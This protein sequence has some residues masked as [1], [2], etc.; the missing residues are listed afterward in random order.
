MLTWLCSCEATAGEVSLDTSGG[1][2]EGETPLPIPNRAVKPLSADGTWPL[3]PGRVGRRRFEC[4]VRAVPSGA[5]LRRCGLR[6]FL[7]WAGAW[8]AWLACGSGT[9]RSRRLRRS[10]G[11]GW[12]RAALEVPVGWWCVGVSR[13]AGGGSG[14]LAVGCGRARPGCAARAA[15]PF[16]LR[17]LAP[18]GRRARPVGVVSVGGSALCCGDPS[19]RGL[20]RGPAGVGRGERGSA[21]LGARAGGSGAAGDVG[22]RRP[23]GPAVRVGRRLGVGEGGEGDERVERAAQAGGG[24]RV[25]HAFVD[26]RGR[27][28]RTGWCATGIARAR[29]PARRRARIADARS[30]GGPPVSASRRATTRRRSSCARARR[31]RS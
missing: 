26:S 4:E 19:P 14:A 3:G 17:A 1:H 13:G 31:R 6:G 8:V 30:P 12:C 10:S 9:T 29:D 21:G 23:G 5:A 11:S 27:V 22:V 18:V 25:E 16:R 28:G 24:E 20:L 15:S 7:G 2:G